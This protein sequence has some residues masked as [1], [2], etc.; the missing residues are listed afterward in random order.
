MR[1]GEL[2][3]ASGTTP[4]AATVLQLVGERTAGKTGDAN[5]VLLGLCEAIR[6]AFAVDRVF[7]FRFLAR[8]E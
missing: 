5:A 2:T 8:S 4:P 7:G 1:S 3:D 6:E